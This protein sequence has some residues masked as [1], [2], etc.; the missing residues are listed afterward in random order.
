MT[1]KIH[2]NVWPVNTQTFPKV[3]HNRYME[4]VGDRL[5]KLRLARK[6]SQEQVAKMVGVKQGS[7]TQLETGKTKTP[8]ASNLTKYARLY[9]VDPEWLMTGKGIQQPIE[10]LEPNE[11]DL[12]LIFRDISPEG[13]A[14]IVGRA[15]SI[16]LDEMGKHPSRRRDD[17][18]PDPP[19]PKRPKD[20]H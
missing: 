15:K 12:L 10:A 9:E 6:L 5:K 13:Q 7:Y 18:R 1:A 17:N 11:A 3:I 8:R 14:Y 19:E 2:V 16:Y 4:T 20:G